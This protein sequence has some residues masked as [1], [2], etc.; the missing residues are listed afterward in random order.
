VAEGTVNTAERLTGGLLEA[1][2]CPFPTY[3][4]VLTPPYPPFSGS[5]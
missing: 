1:A 5:R 4:P 3:E 2:F